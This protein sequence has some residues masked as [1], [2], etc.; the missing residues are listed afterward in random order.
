MSEK[1][2]RFLLSELKS[3]RAICKQP[4]CGGVV[5]L[6]LDAISGK[7]TSIRCPVCDNPLQQPTPNNH[8]ANLAKAIE[9]VTT[10]GVADVEF[11]LPLTDDARP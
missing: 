10:S 4:G 6:P 11:S 1:I 2:F 3:L 8:L 5:E 9:S 7:K